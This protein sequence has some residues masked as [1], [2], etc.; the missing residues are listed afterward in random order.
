MNFEDVRVGQLLKDQYGNV[1][2]VQKIGDAPKRIVSLKCIHWQRTVTVE[3][4]FAFTAAGQSW[5]VHA[6]RECLLNAD[7]ST[8]KQ[9]TTAMG[10]PVD[11]DVF[12]DSVG[13]TV[14]VNGITK[15]F[16]VVKPACIAGC[17]VTI[18]DMQLLPEEAKCFATVLEPDNIQIGTRLKD[19]RRNEYVV[20]TRDDE[21]AKLYCNKDVSSSMYYGCISSVSF[22]PTKGALSLDELSL[23]ED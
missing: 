16:T 21:G 17:E 18:A 1:Y 15:Y 7:D 8:V 9:I 11:T 5:W 23:L 3:Y 13:F 19:T 10:L 6:D 14:T 12:S 4:A 20:I 2:K 22:G